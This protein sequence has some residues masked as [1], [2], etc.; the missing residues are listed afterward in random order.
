MS[1]WRPNHS[2][3]GTAKLNG[4]DPEAYLRHILDRIAEYPVNR[5][6][7]LLPWN[8]GVKAISAVAYN[9]RN[10]TTMPRPDAYVFRTRGRATLRPGRLRG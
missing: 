10:I 7:E 9:T 4:L 6:A 3:I 2:L 5:V 8:V 1:A